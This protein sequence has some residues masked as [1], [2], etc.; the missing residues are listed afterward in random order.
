MLERSI[1][2]VFPTRSLGLETTL[3]MRVE[4]ATG[5]FF[6]KIADADCLRKVEGNFI[7]VTYVCRKIAR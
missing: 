3:S 7:M 5:A 1:N 4:A 6:F 2:G